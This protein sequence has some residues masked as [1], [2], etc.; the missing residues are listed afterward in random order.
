M[1]THRGTLGG[2]GDTGDTEGTHRDRLG[3]FG[4]AGGT[5]GDTLGTLTPSE[6]K[7]LK[8]GSIWYSPG[9]VAMLCRASWGGK[10]TFGDIWGRHR[11][12]P[13]GMVGG[14]MGRCEVGM[15]TWGQW[16]PQLE[17]SGDSGDPKR[18]TWGQWG[19]QGE[20][21][22]TP[23]EGCGV[24][25]AMGNPTGGCGANGE[26]KERRPGP[27]L[28]DVGSMGPWG[29]QLEDVEPMGTS[30]GGHEDLN[31]RM[32]GQRGPWG[33]RGEWG[34]SRRA[35]PRRTPRRPR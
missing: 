24:N 2:F 15:A 27:Q 35:W 34:D 3:R 31:W 33:E 20:D 30:R 19:P 16:G 12:A 11:G 21:M 6:M 23:T 7:V 22:G 25:G 9:S 5:F 10:G 17:N 4:D 14:G 8:R 1:G 26:L 18:R 29:T 32:W 28:E 13:H